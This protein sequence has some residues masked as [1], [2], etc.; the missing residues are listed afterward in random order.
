MAQSEEQAGGAKWATVDSSAVLRSPN[1]PDLSFFSCEL[2]MVMA[3][4][5]G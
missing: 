4:T 2:G 3:T 1:A 5:L